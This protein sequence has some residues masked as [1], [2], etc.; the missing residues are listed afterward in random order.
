MYYILVLF[1]PPQPIFKVCVCPFP[2]AM[3]TLPFLA[4]HTP[5]A[6]HLDVLVLCHMRIAHVTQHQNIPYERQSRE[7]ACREHAA[8]ILGIRHILRRERAAQRSP[9]RKRD[10]DNTSKQ[11]AVDR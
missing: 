6:C 10:K 5:S 9:Y 3:G 7:N 2:T 8:L 1:S 4:M 11:E